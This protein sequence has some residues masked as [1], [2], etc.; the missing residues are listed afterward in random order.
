M[1]KSI[2]DEGLLGLKKRERN[3]LTEFAKEMELTARKRVAAAHK[4]EE[5]KIEESAFADMF[6]N[7]ENQQLNNI[8]KQ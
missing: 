5:V 6:A 7:P 8:E 4:A 2:L 3:P 1:H